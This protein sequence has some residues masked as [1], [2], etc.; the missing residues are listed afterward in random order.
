M[1]KMCVV[2][3]NNQFSYK[4]KLE[5]MDCSQSASKE[6]EEDSDIGDNGGGMMILKTIYNH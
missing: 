6:L 5:T 3:I 1:R 2:L 4:V